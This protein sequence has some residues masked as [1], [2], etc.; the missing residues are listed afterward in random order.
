MST[1]SS[2]P[3]ARDF[4]TQP[5]ARPK[6][7][8]V[9]IGGDG[10]V[11]TPSERVRLGHSSVNNADMRKPERT[12]LLHTVES[13]AATDSSG[14]Q[15]QGALASTSVLS[16]H[17]PEDVSVIADNQRRKPAIQVPRRRS[18]LRCS[19]PLNI[20]RFPLTVKLQRR[21]RSCRA[22]NGRH[23]ARQQS[24]RTKRRVMLVMRDRWQDRRFKKT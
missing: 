2:N 9:S 10:D 11:G 13:D 14:L 23:H 4:A 22:I 17:L 12:A 3:V 19:R 24:Q 16:D 7:S 20:R 1:P 18:R 8:W 5:G 21:S 6:R 15:H